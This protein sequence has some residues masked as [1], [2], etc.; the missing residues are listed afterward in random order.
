MKMNKMLVSL[1]GSNI[2]GMELNHFMMILLI[3]PKFKINGWICQG[4]LRVLVKKLL[5]L[6]LFHP[7]P[8]NFEGMKIWDFN[9]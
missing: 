9:F 3:D 8:L 6:F 2:E 5:N 4:I 7:I 1:F